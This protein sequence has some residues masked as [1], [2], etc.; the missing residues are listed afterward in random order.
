MGASIYTH[1]IIGLRVPWNAVCKGRKKVKAFK[2]NYPEDWDFDPQSSE[3][4]W[5]EKDVFIEGWTGEEHGD[6]NLCGYD[7]VRKPSYDGPSKFVFIC[8]RYVGAGDPLE[9]DPPQITNLPTP[10]EEQLFKEKMAELGLLDEDN[11]DD[12]GLWAYGYAT[13]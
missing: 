2:H 6:E 1:A 10:R 7:I 11:L 12:Y 4:L 8:L 13:P 5:H 3:K 9:G